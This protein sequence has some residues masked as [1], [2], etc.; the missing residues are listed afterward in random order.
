MPS[1]GLLRN[2]DLL[3]KGDIVFQREVIIQ[4][5]ICAILLAISAFYHFYLQS[6]KASRP[7]GSQDEDIA[8]IDSIIVYPIKSC[9]GV[10]LDS[11]DITRKGFEYDRRW[12]IVAKEKLQWL[13]LRE[14]PKL[15]FIV[16]SFEVA[17]GQEVMT[18][19]YSKVSGKTMPEIDVPL[20]PNGEMTS[21]WE[22]LPPLDF[23]GSTAQGRVVEARQTRSDWTGTPSEW[24]SEVSV[25]CVAFLQYP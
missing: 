22:L 2:P 9:H 7:K 8:E 23:Y 3:L 16:P 18:L 12:L 4:I 17:D 13:S 11:V 10:S 21:K 1:G 25:Y 24:I 14:E 19:R 5:A 20:K 15:T 6:G